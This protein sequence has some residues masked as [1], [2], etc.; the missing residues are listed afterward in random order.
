MA[1][2]NGRYTEAAQQLLDED[3]YVLQFTVENSVITR[4]TKRDAIPR[5]TIESGM[6]GE[7]VVRKVELTA[8]NTF[9]RKEKETRH[10]E[11]NRCRQLENE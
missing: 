9:A 6:S 2:P 1:Y 5:I 10:E 4:K 7:D 8:E 3:G 11:K